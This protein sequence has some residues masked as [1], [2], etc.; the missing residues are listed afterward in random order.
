MNVQEREVVEAMRQA[1]QA[2]TR[3]QE[4][5]ERVGYGSMVLGP[6]S[7]AQ[8]AARYALDTAQGRT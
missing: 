5:A 7:D 1:L 2:L 8:K 3:A 4:L 6:L